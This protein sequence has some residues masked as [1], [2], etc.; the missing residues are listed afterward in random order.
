MNKL[1]QNKLI[2]KLNLLLTLLKNTFPK[3]PEP[4]LTLD[5]EGLVQAM[6]RINTYTLKSKLTT[7]KS[8]GLL[9]I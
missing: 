5:E 6:W 1:E 8:F 2:S 9:R 7:M 4:V 3:I